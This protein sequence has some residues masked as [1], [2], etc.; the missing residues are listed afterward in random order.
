MWKMGTSNDPCWGDA[1]LL[2]PRPGCTCRPSENGPSATGEAGTCVSL[3]DVSEVR[4]T[5]WSASSTI[6]GW[7][8]GTWM[9]YFS[10]YREYSSQLTNSYFFRGVGQPPTSEE[11][12]AVTDQICWIDRIQQTCPMF[13]WNSKPSLSKRWLDG[14]AHFRLA[15]CCSQNHTSRTSQTGHA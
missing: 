11:G 3:E 7:W 4:G 1:G 9:D 2:F 13:D 14:M 12:R 15:P 5:F 6:P 10:I 8:F